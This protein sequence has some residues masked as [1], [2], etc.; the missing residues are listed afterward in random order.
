MVQ[1][2]R[3]CALHRDNKP[4][5]LITTP[6]PDRPWQ[7]VAT[8]LFQLKGIDYLIVIDYFSRYVEVAAMQKTTKSS[9]VIRAL[10]SIFARH[11]T[12]E[13]VQSDNGPQFDS[14][15]FSYFAKEWGFK[16][17]TSSPRFPQSNGE[18]ERGVRTVKNLLTKEK[19]PA[20]GLLAY[21]STPLACKFT[22]AQLL[23]GRQIRNSVP[24]FHTQ[25]NP[26]RHKAKPLPPIGPVTKVFVKDLQRP[27]KVI[28]AASTPRSYQVET[29][30]STIRRNRVHL[31]P[32]PNQQE[33]H[34]P[35]PVVDQD[36]AANKP[37]TP[38][39]RDNPA[40]RRDIQV[41]PVTPILATRP[42]RIKY[43]PQNYDKTHTVDTYPP[44][45]SSVTVAAVT[46]SAAIRFKFL[47]YSQVGN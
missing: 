1:Q 18:V 23:M 7:V 4:E 33:E 40:I 43:R 15:E 17:T 6:L 24:A 28:E 10:K 26:H 34:R 38:V 11:G 46:P 20:K 32:L 42:K 30:T 3:V 5:P 45:T 16:H 37:A 8:D 47:I 19:D 44:Q 22:P 35:L 12:P 29:P 39:R 21:R 41:P 13:Q 36:P 14:A 9:E 27:G 31:T 25:L 2:C